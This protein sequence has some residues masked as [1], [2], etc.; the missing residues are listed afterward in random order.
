MDLICLFH[1]TVTHTS[2]TACYMRCHTHIYV[3][4]EVAGI[5]LASQTKTRPLFQMVWLLCKK[6]TTFLENHWTQHWLACAVTLTKRKCLYQI[7]TPAE[8]R[9]WPLGTILWNYRCGLSHFS[10]AYTCARVHGLWNTISMNC[11]CVVNDI[12]GSMNTDWEFW[13]ILV[14]IRMLLYLALVH[15]LIIKYNIIIQM[16]A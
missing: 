2:L 9:R 6:W 5:D 4:V 15:T 16:R 12:P 13:C 1:S 7:K 14:N 10:H 11:G 3:C 8:S